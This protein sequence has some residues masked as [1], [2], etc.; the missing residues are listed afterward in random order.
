[1]TFK[2]TPDILEKYAQVL[3]DF[4]LGG[5]EGVKPGEVVYLQFDAPALPLALVTYA[6]ILQKG[7]HPMVKMHDEC[8]E[9]LLFKHG[10]DE[11]LEFF[12]KRY[13]KS[14][15][16][17]IDHRI[18]L[19][20]DN[21]P[22]ILKKADPKKIMLANKSNQLFK[23]W[24]FEKEDRGK[25]TWTV[26]LYGTAGMAREA[27]I[28]LEDF[29]TQIIKACFLDYKD[30]IARWRRV[31]DRLKV[32]RAQ[33]NK[34]PIEK[35]HLRSSETDLWITLGEQRQWIGGGGR[36]IPSFE[37]FTSPD[38]RGTEGYVYF[39]YPLYRYGNLI[40]DIRLQFKHGKVLR[41]TASK[42][43]KL[44]RELVAQPGADRIGEYSLTDIDF[45]H[46]DAFMANTLYDENYGGKH[47]NT[48]LALGSSFHEVYTGNVDT[49]NWKALGF[50]DSPE[51][52]DIIATN[53]RTVTAHLQGGAKKVIY[54]RGHFQL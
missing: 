28:S 18:Y 2:P 27:G 39:D 3:V 53:D 4:A 24:L 42:N 25:L 35:L 12:P 47:G 51:H 21:N 10:N 44:L 22:F 23:K 11:Q 26:C 29:W 30:P 40:K 32:Y 38:W 13:F 46:I 6:H 20:A 43:E 48:H 50:N 8:F 36:N 7:G 37:I 34:M 16:Q 41:A 1:M 31:F 49:A 14:L 52:T 45:S 5:G 17:T 19:I 33:L 15:I 54:T 9:P